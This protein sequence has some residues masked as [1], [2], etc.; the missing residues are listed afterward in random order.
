MSF[1]DIKLRRWLISDPELN[2]LST[3]RHILDLK[4]I[5]KTTKKLKIFRISILRQKCVPEETLFKMLRRLRKNMI[6]KTLY[7]DSFHH[8]PWRWEIWKD[9][10]I[11]FRFSN[12]FF[13]EKPLTKIEENIH[14]LKEIVYEEN[15][16][17]VT[18]LF[19]M[20]ACGGTNHL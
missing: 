18:T 15:W 1:Y 4:I 9:E 19:K 7:L 8:Q 10:H 17:R 16:E 2:Y 5:N 6:Q 13:F 14:I 12:K 11:Q 20:L 3:P